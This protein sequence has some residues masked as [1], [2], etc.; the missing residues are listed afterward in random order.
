M[1][2]LLRVTKLIKGL[3]WKLAIALLLS[4]LYGA[5]VMI[6][7]LAIRWVVNNGS[8]LVAGK[9]LNEV[10]LSLAI[11]LAILL[12]V[13]IF[14]GILNGLKY[15]FGEHTYNTVEA[16]LYKIIYNKSEP[17]SHEYFEATPPGKIQEK[18][19]SGVNGYM[20]WLVFLI[21]DFLI[22]AVGMIYALVIISVISPFSGLLIFIGI[23]IYTLEFLR[24]NKKSRK[25]WKTIR[26]IEEKKF[27]IFNENFANFS[28]VRSM[29]A[30]SYQKNRLYKS[31]N[32]VKTHR[33]SY[34][35]MWAGSIGFRTFES[36]AIVFIVLTYLLFSLWQVKINTGDII[37]VLLLCWQIDRSSLWFSRFLTSTNQQETNSKRLMDFLDN[38]PITI[39]SEDATDLENIK[40][41]EFK[42]ISFKYPNTEK[43]AIRNISFKLEGN[44]SIALVGPSG[45]GKSTI[46]K[47]L[48]RFYEPTE[49]L[50]LINDQ[51]IGNFKQNSIRKR[52]GIVM[53]DITL[54][55]KSIFENLK[56][57]NDKADDEQIIEAA[58]KSQSEEFIKGLPK[59]YDTLVGERGIKLSGGQKQ[60]VAI[61]R[62]I[63]KSPDLIILDEATSS[64]D[65]SSEKLVQEGLSNLLANKMT[66]IIAHRLSTIRHSDQIIVLEK[67]KIE[68]IGNHEV[69]IKA[70]GLYAKLYKLQSESGKISL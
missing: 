28:T 54:F 31:V 33:D 47:L 52:M 32:D 14:F 51:P 17:I 62:A 37:L 7:P 46:T 61:A 18:V 2:N 5:F 6:L 10:L 20:Q 48:L 69:L 26:K 67:G 68:E 44:K 41:I 70:N 38:T 4:I 42:N 49:G 60:R 34:A 30:E 40:T 24:T 15:W 23:I 27:G 3:Y 66:V 9:T 50:I 55:N 1:K 53:Q 39:D 16:N 64:L 59:K 58:R 8:S 29:S 35:K 11:F 12:T 21:G 56:M 45:V 36:N 13:T 65:S 57:A 19:S 25:I 22:T 63:L 43:Y